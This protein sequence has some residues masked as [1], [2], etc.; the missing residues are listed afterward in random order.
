[1]LDPTSWILDGLPVGVWVGAVPDGRVAY[2]NPAFRV[3]LGMDAVDASVI[4][5]VPTTYGVF[6]R[7]GR[8]YPVDRLPF[9]LA[10]ASGGPVSMDDIVLH[11]PD[12]TRRNVRAFAHPCR[13]AAGSITHVIVAFIDITREVRAESERDTIEARLRLAV[14]HSPVALFSVDRDGTITLSEGAG[15]AALGVRPGELVGR[16]VFDLYKDHPT[17]PGY[18]RRALAGDSFN[19]TVQVGELVFD[20]WATPLCGADGEIIG[21]LGLS[22]D[23]TEIRRLQNKVIQDDRMRAMGTLAASVAHEINNPLTYVLGRLAGMERGLHRITHALQT[24]DLDAARVTAARLAEELETVRHG[25]ERIATITRDLKTFTRPADAHIAPVD[26]RSVVES[27]LKLTRKEVEARAGLRTE[28]GPLVPVLGNEA[29]LTQV[30][31]NLVMNAVQSLSAGEPTRDEILIAA[32]AEGDRVVID[33]SDTGL[34]VPPADRERIFEPFVTTKPVG[35]GTGLGLFVS[36]NLVRDSGGEIVVLDRPGGGA[37]FRVTLPAAPPGTRVAAAPPEP[38]AISRGRILLV[39]DDAL[40]TESLVVQLEDAGFTVET[41][42]DGSIALARLLG[43]PTRYDL[44]YC[45]LMMRGITG[46]DLAAILGSRAPSQLERVVFMT[47]G[48]FTPGAS[49]F[50]ES[51]RDCCV[52]KPFDPVAEARRRLPPPGLR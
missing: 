3:I 43:E 12:G 30:V 25:V 29:R 15:L 23:V 18:I 41:T 47:G 6:D 14:D 22:N 11:R 27:V 52:E 49:A 46:M 48:A 44:V 10:L 9:S 51:H 40:V 8:P 37:L 31:M 20:T 7:A 21:M 38:D 34:G 32:H 4:G 19:Y 28:L 13:D 33:V 5:D 2:I 45:D 17:I 1:M 50:V 35:Q 42:D 24:A 26:V 39:D 16:C 36:R